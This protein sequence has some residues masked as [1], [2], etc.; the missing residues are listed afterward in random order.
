MNL[1]F[2]KINKCP[3]QP[4]FS[5]LFNIRTVQEQR[6]Q[7][8]REEEGGEA[9]SILLCACYLVTLALQISKINCKITYIISIYYIYILLSKYKLRI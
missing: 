6:Q 3:Q 2:V 1:I 9:V 5:F 4:F 7:G 8:N